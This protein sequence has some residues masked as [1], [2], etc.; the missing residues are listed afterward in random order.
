MGKFA[1]FL[2]NCGIKWY[3]PK[4][5][6]QLLKR[7]VKFSRKNKGRIF[8]SLKERMVQIED[9]QKKATSSMRYDQYRR[10]ATPKQGELGKLAE[11]VPSLRKQFT[12]S[13]VIMAT[14][15]GEALDSLLWDLKKQIYPAKQVIVCRAYYREPE[16]RPA[17]FL[18]DKVR[19]EFLQV[20]S[21]AEAIAAT[22]GDYVVFLSEGDRAERTALFELCFE[23]NRAGKA[24]AAL[25][26]D[27][28]NVRGGK[29]CEPYYKPGW[30]P[31]LFLA[32]D[33][34]RN[35][36]AIGRKALQE[37]GPNF[38]LDFSLFIYDLLLK[39][40]EKGEVSHLPGVLFHLAD[41]TFAEDYSPSRNKLREEALVRRGVK[42]KVG[43]NEYFNTMIEYEVEGEPLVSIIVPTC[44]TQD[45]IDKCIESIYKNTTYNNYE[46]IV[47][48]NSRRHPGYGQKRLKKQMADGKCRILYVNEPFNW[49]R[50]NNLAAKEAKGSFLLFLNDDTEV[51][52]ADWLERLL[53]E[54]ARP[55]VGM[56]GP[57]LLYPDGKVQSAG[58]FLVDHGGGGRSYY[59][60]EEEKSRKYHDMLHFTRECSFVIGACIMVQRSKFE[61][62]NGFDEALPLVGNEMDFGLRMRRAGYRNL[63]TPSAKLTHKERV[64][65]GDKS[66][67]AADA[68]I[69]E[70]LGN[71][72]CAGENYF[73]IYLDKHKN[74]PCRDS[75][76]VRNMLTGSPTIVPSL[77]RSIIV[78][79]LDHI[80]DNIIDLPAVRKLRKLFPQA[81]LDM[82]CAPWMK[83]FWEEQ[84]EIDRVFTFAFFAER[85]QFGVA[86]QDVEELQRVIKSLAREHYDLSVHMRRHEDTKKVAEAIADYCLAYSA[87]AEQD[88]CW[89]AVPALKEYS[90]K[91]PHWT[92]HDQMLSL[93]RNLAYEPEL[94]RPFAVSETAEEKVREYVKT[95]PVFSAPVVIGIHAGSGGD[96][97]QWGERKFGLLCNLIL[98]HTQGSIV[99]FGGKSEIPIN[100]KILSC[101]SDRSRVVSVAGQHSLTEFCALVKYVDYFVGNNSGPKHISGM[102]GVP[103][104]TIDGPS[105]D[106]EW[107]APGPKNMSV[108][109][110]TACRP[111]YF[112]KRAQCPYDWLCLDRLGPG[113]VWR[114]LERLMILYPKKETNNHG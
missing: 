56:V 47:V 64:S 63:Y 7:G 55:G 68:V 21:T 32:N 19:E 101:V 76:P 106:F 35:S 40:S 16:K 54:A 112:Y 22:E 36:V 69:W 30:S 10:L 103:T 27:H 38:S 93:V 113:D 58:V 11:A 107:A 2:K 111:C 102:Q 70:K 91:N 104:L 23:L 25:Y 18:E 94:D 88:P 74:T 84:P 67:T 20:D 51:I 77:I 44:Y 53:A 92:M 31:D 82:L 57:L 52:T 71:E 114:G 3:T 29:Y 37:A 49:S 17:D 14:E 78:V 79:K 98:E 73:N 4:G 65:R 80:G 87:E 24:C 1:N 109:K 42:A 81:R 34:I 85:S 83:N 89:Y 105:G 108:K 100:E 9:S 50:L 5:M 12:F 95:Q 13:V 90:G 72:L 99:L 96:F 97:R 110:E 39:V 15:G 86:G 8:R 6:M 46:I 28:D 41:D 66:E 48:D 33:Y 43:V 59:L 62:I 45:Y 26:T 61:E 75:H 60:L